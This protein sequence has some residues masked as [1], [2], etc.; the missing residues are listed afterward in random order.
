MPARLLTLALAL[1][2]GTSAG[3][4]SLERS[5]SG[6][7]SETFRPRTV[8]VL[9]AIVGSH[10][11]ARLEAQ[12]AMVMALAE[13][14]RFDRVFTPADVQ[15]AMQAKGEVDLLDGYLSKLE[16]AGLSDGGTG[17]RLSQVLQAD[18]LVV[19]K[20]SAWE[21]GR[22]ER[23][24]FGKVA[25]TVRVVDGRRGAIV[26]KANDERTAHYFMFK[27][28]LGDLAA[29]ISRQMVEDMPANER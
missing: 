3:C 25:L 17:M 29:D 7:G 9:P 24:K 14:G 6:P 1:W 15:G 19:V 2:L 22:E 12:Q 20:V 18:A 10:E 5:W 23:D 11:G 28:A 26:W 4:S 16:T 27:P 13:S 8:A 21:H